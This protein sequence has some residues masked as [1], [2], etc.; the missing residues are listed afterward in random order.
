M[1]IIIGSLHFSQS[2]AMATENFPL[3]YF[4]SGD[5]W[6]HYFDIKKKIQLKDYKN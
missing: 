4:L 1:E 6:H 3:A 2:P 5:I